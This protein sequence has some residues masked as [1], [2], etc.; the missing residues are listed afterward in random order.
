MDCC[1]TPETPGEKKVT[2]SCL[3]PFFYFS[4]TMQARSPVWLRI[5]GF[6]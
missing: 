2:A 4:S 5:G 1:V 6:A 3:P